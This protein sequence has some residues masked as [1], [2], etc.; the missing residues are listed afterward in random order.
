[1]VL[2][3]EDYDWMNLWFPDQVLEAKVWGA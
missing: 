2:K 1:M 3:V